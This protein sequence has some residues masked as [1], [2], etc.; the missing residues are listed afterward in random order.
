MHERTWIETD[1]V[2][3]KVKEMQKVLQELDKK[4]QNAKIM[5]IYAVHSK[6]EAVAE[7]GELQ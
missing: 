7:L 6:E 5:E 2:K 3:E 1:L 4:C